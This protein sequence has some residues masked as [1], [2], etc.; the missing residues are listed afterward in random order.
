MHLLIG[1]HHGQDKP[2]NVNSLLKPTLNEFDTICPET[3]VDDPISLP[4]CTASLRC[5]IA[6]GSMGSYL[7]GTKCHTYWA[8]DRG[9]K[10]GN[11]EHSY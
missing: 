9:P 5:V 8:C 2:T 1:S 3:S 6:N 7:K 4:S 11:G 10:E